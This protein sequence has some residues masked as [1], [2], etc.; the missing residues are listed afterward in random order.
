M[1]N[2]R[3][4]IAEDEP[5]LRQVTCDYLA[6]E[7]Y[8]VVPAGDGEEAL[9]LFASEHPDL[10]VLDWMLPGLSGLEVARRVRSQGRTPIIMVTARGEEPDIIVGLELGADDYLVKPVSLRQLVARVRAVLRRT[11]AATQNDDLVTLGS[12]RIDF[13]GQTVECAGQAVALTTAEFKLLSV[14]ARSPGRVF[15][16]LQLMEAALG[17]YYEGYERTIDSHIS[18]LRRKLL[19]EHMIQT[20]HGSGYKLVPGQE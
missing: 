3:I 1:A 20:V 4:L 6:S 2:E 13:L 8:R 5:T 11:N 16:R 17:D 18:H 14:L 19:V 7:G 12:L 15:S 9:S 10:L